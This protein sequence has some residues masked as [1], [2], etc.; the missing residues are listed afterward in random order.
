LTGLGFLFVIPQETSSRLQ[1]TYARVFR[2]P[3]RLGHGLTLAA[4]STARPPSGT[5]EEY[6][7]L[8][9]NHRQIQNK[10]ANLQGQLQDAQRKI[11][12]LAKLR[13]KPGWENMSFCLAR[14]ITA[15]DPAQNG[16]VIDRGTKHGLAVSQFVLSV[17]DEGDVD[18]SVSVI[19]TISSVETKTARIRLITDPGDPKIIVGIGN[20]NVRGFMEGRGNGTVRITNVQRQ[21]QVSQGDPV[22]TQKG[23]GLDAPIVTARVTQCRTDPE[24]PFFLDITARPVCDIG[25]LSDVAV[26]VAAVPAR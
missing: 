20:L 14:V 15:V 4:R 9:A 8:L 2:W 17:S 11:E 26:V 24:E 1:L 18:Q 12:L 3:L 21:H 5:P 13:E 6:E 7:A 16:L 10:I 22:Y 25:A 23:Q 19:G